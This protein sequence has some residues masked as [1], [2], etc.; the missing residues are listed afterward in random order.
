M[1]EKEHLLLA[2]HTIEEIIDLAYD[3]DSKDAKKAILEGAVNSLKTLEE[4]LQDVI[5]EI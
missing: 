3:G 2:I 4:M 5:K 1:R